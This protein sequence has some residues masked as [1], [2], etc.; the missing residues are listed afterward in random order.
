MLDVKKDEAVSGKTLGSSADISFFARIFLLAA[1]FAAA[2][3]ALWQLSHLMLLAFGS[4]LVAVV[5]RSFADL[6]QSHTPLKP[7]G[8]LALA[9]VIVAALIAAFIFLLGAQISAQV[10]QLF[11]RF[12]EL[13]D[14]VENAIGIS[15]LEERLEEYARRMIDGT[16]LVSR[17]T[18]YSSLVAGTAANLL[19]LLAAGVYL[20][21]NP[22]L[23]R[24]GILLLAAPGVRREL[25]DTLAAL[26]DA[27]R[28]WLLGQLLAMLFVGIL[29]AL[30]LWAL[31]VPSALALG[32]IAG[33]LEFVP[34]IGSV[35]GV[36][37]AAIV[38]LG[39]G[40]ATVAWVIGLYIVIQQVEGMVITPL[41]QEQTVR[42][43]PAVTIFAIIA[44]GLL[45]GPLG[46][47]FATPLT[48]VVF[49][50]VKKLWIRDTLHEDTDLPGET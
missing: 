36:V 26:F 9:I 8:A 12:P 35:L 4:V 29:T 19:L 45:F 24:R 22:D 42:L 50:L 32:L 40:P 1:G 37:P 44:F 11:E 21:A 20:A 41:V 16:S 43:P 5:L 18:N 10:S 14:R 31:G 49:V 39:E 7:K 46:V 34:V 27:L 38:A 15:R 33:L 6:I 13:I 47:L 2:L 17:I 30:G 3:F 23:Y 25:A 28:L 48:V